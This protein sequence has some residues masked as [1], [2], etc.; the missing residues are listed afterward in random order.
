[1]LHMQSTDKPLFDLKGNVII[2]LLTGMFFAFF[3]WFLRPNVPDDR[4]II[5]W[6]VAA[7]TSMCLT[8]VFFLAANMFL[9]VLRDQKQRR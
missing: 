6:L 3:T 7:Y 5:V 8:G 2:L 4:A 1:M 9:V